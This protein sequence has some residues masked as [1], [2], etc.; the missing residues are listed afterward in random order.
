MKYSMKLKSNKIKNQ[1]TWINPD[2]YPFDMYDHFHRRIYMEDFYRYNKLKI[3]MLIRKILHIQQWDNLRELKID[4]MKLI[5]NQFDFLLNRLLNWQ[6]IELIFD[7]NYDYESH[8][9]ARNLWFFGEI[10]IWLHIINVDSSM[11]DMKNLFWKIKYIK[12][13]E[14]WFIR[15]KSSLVISNEHC[16]DIKSW[17]IEKRNMTLKI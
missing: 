16:P 3:D 15:T 6:R 12:K 1:R 11:N 4:R 14:F 10:R 2:D 8:K 17:S 13:N 7:Q 5:R 9:Y